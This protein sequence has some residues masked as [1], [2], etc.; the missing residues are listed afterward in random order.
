MRSTVDWCERN[1]VVSEYI[2]EYWNT[3][4][5][6]CLIISSYCYYKNN[7]KLISRYSEYYVNFMRICCLLAFVGVGT[8][9]FHSTLYYP[10]QLLD[11]L[12]MMLLANEYLILLLS[13]ETTCRVM[14]DIKGYNDILKYSYRSIP[15]IIFVYFINPL[16]QV[17]SFHTMLKVSEISVLVILYKLSANLNRII[18]LKI[19][20]RQMFLRSEYVEKENSE[21]ELMNIMQSNIKKY[22]TLRAHL[23][24]YTRI[25]I[26]MYSSS[27]LIWCVENMFCNYVEPFQLHAIWHVFSSIG[28]YYLNKIILLHCIINKC[29]Y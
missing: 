26:L 7:Y 19:Y 16:F 24:R 1:Y 6:L 29:V 20:D 8:M 9:L 13:L 15:V 4:T 17:I 12:P 3:V 28:V 21:I 14:T 25:G 18:Y 10:F 11:E 5:G 22:I 23:K 27:I 2:A